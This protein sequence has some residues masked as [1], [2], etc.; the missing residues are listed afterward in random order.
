[1]GLTSQVE[2]KGSREIAPLVLMSNKP[3]LP[4]PEPV[5]KI[6]K[7]QWNNGYLNK[8]DIL[9][10]YYCFKT[11]V[12]GSLTSKPIQKAKNPP[13]VHTGLYDNVHA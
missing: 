11:L 13:N 8:S 7:Y 1:M 3:T 2:L 4:S 6:S 12:I 9:E 5:N 10:F